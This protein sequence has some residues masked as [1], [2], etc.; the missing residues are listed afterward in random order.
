[1]FLL[2]QKR[3]LEIKKILC[4]RDSCSN[5]NAFFEDLQELGKKLEENKNLDV[6]ER[7]TSAIA[8]KERL[9]IIN[10]LIGQDR[11]VCELETILNRSQSTI[12][13][14]LRK[15]VAA[16]L[17]QGYKK[18]RFTYYHLFKEELKHNLTTFNQILTI[19]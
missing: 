9:I 16:G 19:K 1:V 8:S 17:I 10:A 5:S 4:T 3:T 6:I 14:H 18:Q 7:F 15:L 12:S 11:C 13:H 2:K